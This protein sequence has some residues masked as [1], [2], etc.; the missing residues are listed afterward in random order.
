MFSSGP[1][2][3]SFRTAKLGGIWILVR[4]FP[5][6]VLALPR[7]STDRLCLETKIINTVVIIGGILIAILTSVF[8]PLH[9][10]PVF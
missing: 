3:P 8:V 7:G 4:V 1:V 2:L 9:F 6:N 10:L 5:V